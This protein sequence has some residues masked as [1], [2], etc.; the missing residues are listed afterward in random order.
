MVKVFGVDIPRI[1]K[2]GFVVEN[3]R[4]KSENALDWISSF[5]FANSS[6]RD[7]V[8]EMLTFTTYYIFTMHFV[9]NVNFN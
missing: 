4:I 9:D 1:G 2:F 3:F 7:C 6:G 5:H 8:M